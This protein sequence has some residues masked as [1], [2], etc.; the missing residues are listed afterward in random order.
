M[1]MCTTLNRKANASTAAVMRWA[2]RPSARH[3]WQRARYTSRPSSPKPSTAQYWPGF[4]STPKDQLPVSPSFTGTTAKA[5][6]AIISQ[7]MPRAGLSRS[8]L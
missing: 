4:L 7:L 5:T 8:V 1:P 3:F 2:K 6:V